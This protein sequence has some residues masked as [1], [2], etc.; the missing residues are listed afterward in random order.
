MYQENQNEIRRLREELEKNEDRIKR[1]KKAGHDFS[2][3]NLHGKELIENF[4]RNGISLAKELDASFNQFAYGWVTGFTMFTETLLK[5]LVDKQENVKD[6]ADKQENEDLI[7]QLINEVSQLTIKRDSRPNITILA[8]EQQQLQRKVLQLQTQLEQEKNKNRLLSLR[9]A[10]LSNKNSEENI[11]RK[12][13]ELEQDVNRLKY[14][15][16]EIFRANLE[17]LLEA[18][19]EFVKS[20]NSY[21]QKQLGKSKKILLDIKK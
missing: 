1:M 8:K 20:N 6:F 9:L 21:A 18:K 15:L 14:R 12:R 4:K 7:N 5:D 19:E 10:K 13:R 17:N 16:D 11:K 3:F 2:Q